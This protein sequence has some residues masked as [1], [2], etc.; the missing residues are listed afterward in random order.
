MKTL[1][2]CAAAAFLAGCAVDPASS[3]EPVTD[4][5]YRTGSNLPART[6][7][8]VHTVSPEE[9]ERARSTAGASTIRRGN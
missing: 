3:G 5:E 1:F 9:F 7:E 8:G 4:K 2:A 6:R